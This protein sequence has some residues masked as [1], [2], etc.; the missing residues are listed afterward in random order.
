MRHVLDIDPHGRVVPASDEVRRALADRAGR[1]A[2]LPSAPDLVIARR[3]PAAG[4][5]VAGPRCILAGDLAALPISDFIGFVHGARLSGALTVS[6]GGVDRTVGFEKGEVR[7]ARSEAPGERLGEV[8]MRLGFVDRSQLDEALAGDGLLGK[9][10]V[11]LGHLD[12]GDLWKCLH[13]Q[14]A[15]VFHAILQAGEGVFALVDEPAPGVPGIDMSVSTQQLLMDGIRRIDEL[16]LFRSRIPGPD[17]FL[18]RR[19]PTRPV[20]LQPLEVR[21][22]ELA[23]GRRTVADVARAAHL[24]VFDATKVLYHLAEAGYLAAAGA[25]TPAANPARRLHDI[26]DGMNGAFLE[27]AARLAAARLLPSFVA[28]ARV[29]LADPG[30]RYAPL[31]RG[32]DI[33]A[34]ATLDREA[35]LGNL[36]TLRGPMLERL[37][38]SGDPG[39]YLF[40]GLREMLFFYLFQAGERLER[41][42]DDALSADAKRRLEAMAGLR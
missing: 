32:L 13:E 28:A 37:E 23:D 7:G 33:K 9:A 14:V 4:G 8:A 34:D 26:V 17:A 27:V 5:P 24:S 38:A 22:L 12:P 19:Q 40:D 11:D 42:V 25:A 18:Y 21:L 6:T 29:F 39:R 1:F 3:T 20:V 16:E 15:G 2:L 10:L 31:W 35:L 30:S 41:G 36:E